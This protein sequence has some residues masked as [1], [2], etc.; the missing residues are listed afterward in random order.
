[1]LRNWPR[2][3]TGPTDVGLLAMRVPLVMGTQMSSLVGSLT[4]FFN[5]QGQVEHISFHGRMGDARPL[6]QLLTQRYQFQ[7]FASATGEKVFQ[8]RSGD[9]VFSELRLRPDAVIRSNAPQQ[10]IV[11]EL[12]FA[13]PGTRRVLPP[14][15]PAF[16]LPPGTPPA[17]PPATTSAEKP[18]DATNGNQ[19]SSGYWNRVHYATPDEERQLQRQR[20]PQ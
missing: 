16:Q 1:M 3:S 6:E 13:R 17:Q 5:A 19:T 10:S 14:H 18:A 15:E 4:Y 2:T 8:V 20:W 11:V 12:E 7:P 9:A